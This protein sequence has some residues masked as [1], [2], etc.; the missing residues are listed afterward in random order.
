MRYLIGVD[1][2]DDH[3]SRGTGFR[4]RSLGLA[5]VEAG[6]ARLQGVSRHQLFVHDDIPYTSHNS[7]LCL[8]T[9]VPSTGKDDLLELCRQFLLRESAAGSDTGLCVSRFEQVPPAVVDFGRRAKGE[10]LQREEAE[11]LA[12][13]IGLHLEGLTGDHG[14]VIGALAAVGLRHSGEDGRF[15]WLE[16][17]RE[18]SGILSAAELLASTGIEAI[19]SL[20]G[21][22]VT[23]VTL[24]RVDPWPR[25][26]L[27]E[28][29]AV[30]LVARAEDPDV[31]YEWQ[32]LERE[33]VRRY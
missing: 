8:D 2:T 1:D 5:L 4:A 21:E 27:L 20:A 26:V 10:V 22:E 28:G 13:E 17:V 14:G 12:A 16:G 9:E 3:Q 15:V 23:D 19:R 33:L 31:D 24:V 25:P 30:L 32:L 29:R 11:A 18:L 7:S 6:Y